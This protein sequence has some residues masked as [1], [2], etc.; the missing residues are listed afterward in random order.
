MTEPTGWP[1]KPST[2][3]LLTAAHSK[4]WSRNS[5][6]NIAGYTKML[7]DARKLRAVL[8]NARTK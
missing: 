7:D 3:C 4:V 8:E 5:E 2:A 6:K 1:N